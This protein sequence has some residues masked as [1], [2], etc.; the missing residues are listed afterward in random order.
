MNQQVRQINIHRFLLSLGLYSGQ[1]DVKVYKGV[2]MV[3]IGDRVEQE[4]IE[5]II[6][7]CEPLDFG[8]YKIPDPS[9]VSLDNYL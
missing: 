2:G 9:G 7:Y 3:F 8:V 6:D 5:K 4:M 1:F